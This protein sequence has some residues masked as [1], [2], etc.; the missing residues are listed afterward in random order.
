MVLDLIKEELFKREDVRETE[1]TPTQGI[2]YLSIS[3]TD[4]HGDEPDVDDVTYG[5]NHFTTNAAITAV[6]API[7]L[8]HGAIITEIVVYGNDATNTWV[9][10]RNEILNGAQGSMGGANIN[11]KDTTLSHTTIDNTAY[12]YTIKV[13]GMAATDEINCAIITYTT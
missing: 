9:M 7:N 11:T 8:P 6:W 12:S 3:Y 2:N 4:F 10:Y 1:T 13:T 5:N